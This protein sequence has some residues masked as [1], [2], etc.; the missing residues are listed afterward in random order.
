TGGTATRPSVF[1]GDDGTL[2]F[3]PG[4]VEEVIEL[5][6]GADA[7]EEPDETIELT[8]SSVTGDAVLGIAQHTVTISASVLPRAS[9]SVDSSNNNEATSPVLDVALDTPSLLTVTVEL[10]SM[11]TATAGG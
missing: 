4:D 9:F 10:A 2:V 5:D 8:L 1:L 11:G 3:T 6:V 7:M